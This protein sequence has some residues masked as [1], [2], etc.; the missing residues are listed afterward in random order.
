VKHRLLVAG[1]VIYP[2]IPDFPT[3]NDIVPFVKN[4]LYV[5]L[6][7]CQ[8]T[9]INLTVDSNAEALKESIGGDLK[10]YPHPIAY[11]YNN[12]K[13][14]YLNGLAKGTNEYNEYKNC[15][16]ATDAAV[17]YCR[18]LIH[19]HCQHDPCCAYPTGRT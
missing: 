11:H 17:A 1:V 2:L 18:Y 9:I 10:I 19:F 14:N 6:T 8:L 3:S 12:Q 15:G 7:I 13:K 5:A 4:M 16:S